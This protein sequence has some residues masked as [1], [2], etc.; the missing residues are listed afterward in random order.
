M[1]IEEKS[2]QLL[3]KYLKVAEDE[4]GNLPEHCYATSI[5]FVS[6]PKQPHYADFLNNKIVINE[7]YVDDLEW[8]IFHEMEHIRTASNIYNNM[9][10]GLRGEGLAIELDSINEA[11]TELSVAK[12]IKRNKKDIYDTSYIEIIFLTRQLGVLLGLLNDEQILKFYKANGYREFKYFIVNMLNNEGVF[13]HI[14]NVLECLHEN[15]LKDL[16]REYNK[17]VIVK[18]H[19]LGKEP[20]LITILLRRHYQKYIHKLLKLLKS[21]HIIN[22]K[23][24]RKRLTLINKYNPYK[25]TSLKIVE[26]HDLKRQ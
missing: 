18:F 16:K 25:N 3:K 7:N 12:M 21:R 15:H 14:Q 6:D 10:T 26:E 4:F 20:S 9:Q 5:E 17:N 23:E 2:K 8:I 19:P 11:M 13:Y 22:D 24:Y 1:N